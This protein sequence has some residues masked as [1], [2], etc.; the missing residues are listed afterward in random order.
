MVSPLAAPMGLDHLQLTDKV[1]EV[2]CCDVVEDNLPTISGGSSVDNVML[3]RAA[4]GEAE[5][6]A[7]AL[8][9][10][11]AGPLSADAEAAA[12][13]LGAAADV[14][15][16]D[17]AESDNE[18]MGH[19]EADVPAPKFRKLSCSEPP[20]SVRSALRPELL[21]AL[22]ARNTTFLPTAAAGA[23]GPA[24]TVV[25]VEDFCRR[26][27]AAE[28]TEDNFY[29][30]NLATVEKLY[31][32]WGAMMPRVHPCY[33]V[34][35]NPDEGLLAVLAALGAGF[36]CASEAEM[37]AV[38]A[39]GVAPERIIYAHPC[40]PPKQIRWAAAA[41][42]NLTTFDTESELH[43]MAAHHP[44]SAMLLRIRADDPAARCQLG[45]KYG[46]ELAAVPHLLETA[47]SLG[48]AVHG[49]SFH[50]GSGA[51]NPAAFVAAIES[52][53]QVFD[54]GLAMGFDMDILDLGGG[55]CG[56]DFDGAGNVDLGGV[57]AAINAALDQHFP[58]DG[59]LRIIAEPG[60]YFAEA[61]ATYACF[62]NGWRGR[63]VGEAS[64]QHYDYF[65]T[66]GL[67]GSMNCLV[68]D[69]AEM[70]LRALRSPLLPAVSASDDA[71][72]FPTTLFGPTCDGLDTV[73]RDVPMPRLRNGD[74]VLF[75]KFGA[76]TAAGA[77][78]FNGIAVDQASVAKHY[79]YA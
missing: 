56:G 41:G 29:V 28:Q 33:A 32:A 64:E 74:F 51:K 24:A 53:R 52:A 67:Y 6:L 11:V 10:A 54:L 69:H 70:A 42:V 57:P 19:D 63:T 4:S 37:A 16:P 48:L 13:C 60:R 36:D 62:I 68:Y 7:L 38:L 21:A 47:A 26:T 27:I 71:A 43:K 2:A 50:V 73:C 79:I 3:E 66:D 40:K 75:P 46:A 39:L 78:A 31:H 23:G 14:A 59:K 15:V 18:T 17:A 22:E 34:K 35:C 45:N 20:P 44:G 25:A 77:V 49:V 76:Y 8:E 61:F 9:R 72:L 58:E 12:A 30:Y 5:G 65:I 55:F 1:A